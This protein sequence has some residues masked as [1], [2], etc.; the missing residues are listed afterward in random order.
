MYS[1]MP[2]LIDSN[3]YHLWA[4]VLHARKL[5]YQTDNKW[6]RGAYVR[7]TIML[8]WTVLEIACQDALNEPNIS[9]SFRQNID[10]TIKNNGSRVLDWAKGTWQQVTK[11]QNL[12]KNCVHRFATENDLFP[13]AVVADDTVLII[14]DAVK[15]IYQHVG[16]EIPNCIEDDDDRGFDKVGF[17]DSANLTIIR[18]GAKKDDPDNIKVT[19]IKGGK[20]HISEILPPKSDPEP[21]V[22]DLLKNIREPISAIRVYKGDNLLSE[23]KLK[24]RGT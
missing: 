15:A 7:W 18:A 19:Y 14:R 9:Y 11:L 17:K 22:E 1:F 24:M 16:K 20:E 3:H 4:D 12:R 23:R 13:E 8:G 6:D 10:N 21:V 5:A 2:K